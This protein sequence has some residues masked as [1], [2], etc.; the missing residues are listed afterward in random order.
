MMAMGL[1]TYR[2]ML[3]TTQAQDIVFMGDS[4][5]ANMALVMTMT[6]ARTGI[7]LPARHVL[8]SPGLDMTVT[9]PETRAA[10][11]SDPWLDIPGG[12]EAVRLYCAGIDAEDWRI[13]PSNGDLSVLPPTLVFS[14]TRDMLYPDTVLFI[15]KARAAGVEI[16]LVVGQGM[17][18]VWPLIEMPETRVARDRIVDWLQSAK[19]AGPAAD[20]PLRTVP[21]L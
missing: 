20:Q 4:A 8:I 9:N 17:I 11:R 18:H 10:A 21:S 15:E 12:L 13:S 16:E 3:E 14:G 6:A 5:G 19:A 1:N 2:S 7:P